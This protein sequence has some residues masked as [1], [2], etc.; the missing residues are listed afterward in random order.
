[1][2]GKDHRL[3]GRTAAGVECVIA[4]IAA[5]S[6]VLA[7][8]AVGRLE[9][10]LLPGVLTHIGDIQIARRSIEARPPRV[11]QP[12]GPDL[13]VAGN[14][15]KRIACGNPVIT[16]RP[17]VAIDVDAQH[18]AQQLVGDVL[19]SIPRVAS[20]AAVTRGDVQEPV[21]G[22]EAYPTA[23]VVGERLEDR[24][25]YQSATRVGNLRVVRHAVPSYRC[26]AGVVCVV[27]VEVTV[28][29]IVR[30]ERQPQQSPFVI[31]G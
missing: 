23:V 2:D 30:M 4:F 28:V 18:L 26:S 9:V 20:T 24:Q 6:V 19:C 29:L 17:V 14:S 12:I 13:I 1:M 31:C 3:G 22:T 21:V 5:P 10:D 15:Y 11:A 16:A 7:A 27:N 25:Q 8:G